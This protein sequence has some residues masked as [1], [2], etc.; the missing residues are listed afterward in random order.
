MFLTLLSRLRNNPDF[1]GAVVTGYAFVGL[2]LVVQVL[3]VPLYLSS[4]GTHGFG[5]LM[6]MFSMVGLIHWAIR[7][8]QGNFMLNMVAAREAGDKTRQRELCFSLRS[9]MTLYAFFALLVSVPAL[10]WSGGMLPEGTGAAI[11]AD[12]PWIVFAFAVYVVVLLDLTVEIWI[13]MAARRQSVANLLLIAAQL[14]FLA[15]VVPYLLQGGRVFGV[16]LCI[17]AGNF[18]AAVAGR[19]L[20]AR[21]TSGKGAVTRSGVMLRIRQEL[22]GPGTLGFF[23]YGGQVA[24]SFADVTIIGFVFGAGTAGSYVLIWKIAEVAILLIWRIGDHLK[25]ELVAMAEQNDRVR[26]RRIYRDGLWMMAGIALVGGLV[27]A[28]VGRFIVAFWVGA[29]VTPDSPV[30]YALAGGAIFWLGLAYLSESYAYALGRIGRLATIKTVEI[31]AKLGLM[32]ALFGS[33]GVLA[34]L[35]AINVVHV[36]GVAAAYLILGRS[37]IAEKPKD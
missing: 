29:A 12:W 21:L 19:F 24:L 35:I 34:P 6:V 11:M 17:A 30:A 22:L 7:W 13:L 18:A 2:N 31:V 25:P 1:A 28:L 16:M 4:L 20:R 26:L 27:Y 10:L 33:V 36:L 5:L 15:I 8:L 37:M 23:V 32:A 9:L 3:L 14:G